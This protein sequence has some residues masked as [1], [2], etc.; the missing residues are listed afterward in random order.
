[1]KNGPV[2][3]TRPLPGIKDAE[4][5]YTK[6]ESPSISIDSILANQLEALARVSKQLLQQSKG[7]VLSKDEIQSLATCIKV[8][9][10]LKARENELLEGLSDEDLEKLSNQEN[11]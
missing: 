7:F 8:T 3:I 6:V 9:M 10:D 4:G 2:T 1:M 11:S 5:A